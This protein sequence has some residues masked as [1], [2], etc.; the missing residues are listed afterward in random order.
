M[1]YYVINL[2]TA[3]DRLSNIDKYF[4][5]NKL[6]YNVF[7]AIN[8]KELKLS[9]IIFH[10]YFLNRN[11][12]QLFNNY[13]GSIAC[14]LSHIKLWKQILNNSKDDINVILEDDIKFDNL[15]EQKIKY[16][17][18]RLP[19]DWDVLYLGRKYLSGKKVNKYFIKGHKISKRG[20]NVSSYGYVLKKKGSKK[21]LNIV[22]P[23]TN[24]EQ[25]LTLRQNLDKYNA[26]FL[27]KPIVFHENFKSCISMNNN[28][29]R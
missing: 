14:S 13:R 21:L 24:I 19:P 28:N 2:E 18:S 4:Q 29:H 10:P 7:K 9:P 8:G 26:Y 3:T 23:L 25:D 6:E 5:N 17:I 27:I 11:S 15:F 12:L 1:N 16:Y 20:Y 22:Y